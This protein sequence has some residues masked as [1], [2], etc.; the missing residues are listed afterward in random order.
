M[1]FTSKNFKKNRQSGAANLQTVALAPWTAN[2]E[3]QD[4]AAEVAKE[5][6]AKMRMLYGSTT[7]TLGV[8]DVGRSDDAD[9]LWE[10]DG[11][12]GVVY[13]PYTTAEIDSW[14]EQ[15]YFTAASGVQLRRVKR[16]RTDDSSL[17]NATSSSE[18]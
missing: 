11:Y 1:G 7:D 3:S 15:G 5:V 6:E 2:N 13:G 18:A 9:A 14:R 10:Y 17:V 16:N 8:T 12:D 4:T